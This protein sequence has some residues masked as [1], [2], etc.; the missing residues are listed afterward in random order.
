M[1]IGV[2]PPLLVGGLIRRVVAWYFP[3]F[4]VWC[5]R[6]IPCGTPGAIVDP[7][8]GAG[9]E[10]ALA[11]GLGDPFTAVARAGAPATSARALA[12][13]KMGTR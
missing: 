5:I 13:R 8:H 11:T 9:L 7:R 10:R 3:P 1:I 2:V 4:P 12:L 6:C